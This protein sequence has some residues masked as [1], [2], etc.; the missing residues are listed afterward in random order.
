[1]LFR[2]PLFPAV[3]EDKPS[4][5]S[6]VPVIASHEGSTEQEAVL[7]VDSHTLLQQARSLADQGMLEEARRLCENSLAR[8]RLDCEAHLLLAA[9]CQELGETAT[10]LQ[11]LQR[12]IYLAP[13]F[14]PAHFVLGSIFF[15][16]EEHKRGLRSMETV[17]SLLRSAP[18]DAM[19][20]GTDGLMAGRLLEMAKAY[21]IKGR[22]QHVQSA[23]QTKNRKVKANGHG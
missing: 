17:V 1:M 11:A 8:E 20:P 13:D 4:A 7:P 9:I 18:R 2:S 14:A 22:G 6:A 3:G 21:L 12:A 23:P 19:V 10:A 15:K 5:D 16:Q